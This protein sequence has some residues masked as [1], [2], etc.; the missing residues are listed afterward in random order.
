[1]PIRQTQRWY[2]DTLDCPKINLP[3][4]GLFIGGEQVNATA[5]QMNTGGGLSLSGTGFLHITGGNL[6]PAV[7]DFS[8]Y[9]AKLD[10]GN[11]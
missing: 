6:D 4:G 3:V 11:F 2:I 5:T 7:I 10:G 8:P 1:M 9:Q